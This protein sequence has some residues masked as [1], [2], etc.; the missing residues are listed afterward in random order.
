M[1][2]SKLSF[3]IICSTLLFSVACKKQK[4]KENT[5]PLSFKVD[6]P[7]SMINTAV[8]GGR[9]VDENDGSE[10]YEMLGVFV[11]V[12]QD[13]AEIVDNIVQ[14]L[15]KHQIDRALSKDFD[16][17]DGKT[18]NVTVTEQVVFE[19]ETWDLNAVVTDVESGNVGLQVFWNAGVKRGV[20]ILNPYVLN[21]NDNTNHQDAMYKVAYSEVENAYDAQMIVSVTVEEAEEKWGINR[22]KLFVG[23]NGDQYD[24]YGNS[25][26]PTAQLFEASPVARNYAFVAKSND[27]KG[28]SVAKVAIPLSTETEGTHAMLEAN[29]IKSIISDY[30]WADN[31]STGMDSTTLAAHV[32]AVDAFTAKALQPAYFSEAEGFLGAGPDSLPTDF[33]TTFIDLSLLNCF[34]PKNIAAMTVSF[35]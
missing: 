19:G 1:L 29:S 10:I 28:I 23:K 21:N 9:S 35:N 17:G 20:A 7:Q 24:I 12:G 3:V 5:I 22:L 26:H 27:A 2:K 32:S 15:K 25:N 33:S 18:K 31:D 8:V 13:A 4:G 16:G 14:G 6:V 30:Y 34:V 11:K